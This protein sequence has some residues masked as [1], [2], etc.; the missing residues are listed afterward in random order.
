MYRLYCVRYLYIMK[1]RIISVVHKAL[2]RLTQIQEMDGKQN[3]CLQ[4]AKNH[5]EVV[6]NSYGVA[7]TVGIGSDKSGPDKLMGEI[8]HTSRACSEAS[9]FTG[10]NLVLKFLC[11]PTPDSK[12]YYQFWSNFCMITVLVFA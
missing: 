11:S 12:F 7:V 10:T 4:L 9:A 3:E 1:K 5:P 8:P 2:K 6:T